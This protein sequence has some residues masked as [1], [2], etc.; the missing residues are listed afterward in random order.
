MVRE[1]SNWRGEKR[2]SGGE[3]EGGKRK[4]YLM[5]EEKLKEM[6]VDEHKREKRK[7]GKYY[8]R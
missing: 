2:G 4:I 1:K 3:M 6:A 7:G 5:V 8:G